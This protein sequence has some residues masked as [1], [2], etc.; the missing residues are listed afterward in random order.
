MPSCLKLADLENS[1]R[2]MRDKVKTLSRWAAFQ[3]GF[4]THLA[5]IVSEWHEAS[6]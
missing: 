3:H 1:P 6:T 4:E 5:A 2:E